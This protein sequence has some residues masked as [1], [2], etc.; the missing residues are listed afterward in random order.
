MFLLRLVRR[1]PDSYLDELQRQMAVFCRRSVSVS[2]IWRTLYR[3]GF[4]RKKL[5]KPAAERSDERRQEYWD[6]I[7]EY[8]PGQLV[9]VDESSVDRRT[10]YRGYGYARRNE[11]AVRRAFRVRGARYSI[12][13]ALTDKG[14]IALRVVKGSFTA[15]SF[16]EF[17]ELCLDNMQPFPANRSV[18]VMDNCLIH[19]S[20]ETLNMIV[21]RGMRYIFLPPYSPDLNPIEFAFS[22]I[23]SKLR[24]DG[25]SVRFGMGGGAEQD[26]KVTA[27]LFQHVFSVTPQD[28]QSWFENCNYV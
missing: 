21:E 1:N 13:P 11:P 10:T 20:P 18:I 26:N 16:R 5:S 6:V 12:L 9:F 2:T 23:K 28:A 3:S 4:T 8:R 25:D 22:S 7:H 17:I 15:A 27:T 19:K 24:R 14:I